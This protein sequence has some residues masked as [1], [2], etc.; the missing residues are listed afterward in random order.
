MN[1]FRLAPETHV[2][3]VRLQVSDLDEALGFYGGILGFHAL[4]VGA[5]EAQL[6]AVPDGGLLATLHGNPGAIP[7]PPRTTGLFH[8]A[9]RYPSRQ[10]LGKALYQLL[11]AG[12]PLLGYSDHKV[13]EA[14]YLA[15]PDRLGLELYAD[16]PRDVWPRKDGMIAMVTDPLDVEGVLRAAGEPPA[17]GAAIDPAADIGH[18]HL[19]V[20][21]LGRARSFYEGLL[22]LEV[23]QEDYTGALFL[24]AGGY[25]H[26]VGLNIWAG[27]DAARPPAEAVGLRS[28]S[29]V[30][31]DQA[32]V[33]S[34]HAR[35]KAAGFDPADLMELGWSIRDPDGTVVEIT[36]A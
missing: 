5:D 26:Y 20:A 25:H 17:A 21:D 32:A 9:I 31:P 30:L 22:G 36:T 27:R 34:L 7:K 8:V 10:S 29:L 24:A 11:Q 28:Y 35:V 19:Q 12:W 2:G 13:S 3:H 16:K 15:D 14:V 4:A 1:P 18:V 23:M 6:R 33:S